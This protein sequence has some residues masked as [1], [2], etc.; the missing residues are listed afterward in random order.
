MELL[1]EDEKPVKLTKKEIILRGSI[2]AL[3]TTTPSLIVFI[4]VWYFLDDVI[5]GAI[6]G[7]IVHFIAMGFSLKISKKLLVKK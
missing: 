1:S 7:A 6:S 2:L 3:I 5:V 4:L